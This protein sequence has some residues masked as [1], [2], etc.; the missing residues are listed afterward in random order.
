[1]VVRNCKKGKSVLLYLFLLQ[2]KQMLSVTDL[3]DILR[4]YAY[5]TLY[6]QINYVNILCK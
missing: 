3:L 2:Q 5:I 6:I 4:V 1:M